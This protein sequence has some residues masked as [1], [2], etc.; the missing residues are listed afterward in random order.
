[1]PLV[2][3]GVLHRIDSLLIQ[4]ILD[5]GTYDSKAGMFDLMQFGTRRESVP[6]T[7]VSVYELR[8]FGAQLLMLADGLGV[9]ID[10]V[11]FEMQYAYADEA[12]DIA[13]GRI[14]KGTICGKRYSFTATIDDKP[15]LKIE[16]VT[17]AGPHVKPE[18]PQGKGWYVTAHGQPSMRLSMEIA[19]DGKAGPDQ[20]C[21]AAAMHVVHS[22]EPTCAAPPGI[23]TLLDLPMIIG[24]GT[25]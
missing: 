20:A 16:H 11:M 19:I 1:M 13:A 22:I 21:L 17:R 5:Y 3:S 18:W 7:R 2:L 23:R 9:N 10:E 15:K 14:E 12:Y 8:A 4:E 25:L 6:P 24:R